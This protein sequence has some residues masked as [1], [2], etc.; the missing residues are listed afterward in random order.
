MARRGI[1]IINAGPQLQLNKP[2][3]N[4]FLAIT[5]AKI[6]ILMAEISIKVPPLGKKL[7]NLDSSFLI[8]LFQDS[9]ILL[10]KFLN[11]F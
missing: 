4:L 6:L 2:N 7:R 11:K 9:S 5:F 10:Q 8:P 1:I 3:K